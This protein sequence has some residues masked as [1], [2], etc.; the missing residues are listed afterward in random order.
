MTRTLLILLGMIVGLGSA[1][2]QSDIDTK[3]AVNDVQDPNLVVL[4]IANE[5]YKEQGFEVEDV[6]FAVRDGA[7]FEAYCKKTL[8]VKDDNINFIYD[9]TGGK[10]RAALNKLR[11]RLNAYAGNARAI[12]Y[13]SGHGMPDEATK[14]AY[15]LPVDGLPADPESAIKTSYIYKSLGNMNSKSITVFLDACFSGASREGGSLS[16]D[17]RGVNIKVKESPVGDNTV[18][19]SAAQ[20]TETAY[21]YREMQH[22]LFTYFLLEKLQQSKGGVTLGELSDYVTQQ[23][24]LKSSG[25]GAKDQTPIIAAAESNKNWR[26]WKMAATPA[27]KYV[28]TTVPIPSGGD[29]APAANKPSRPAATATASASTTASKT[30]VPSK[31]GVY[32]LLPGIYYEMVRVD[33]GTFLM[34]SK[35]TNSHSSFYMSQPIHEVALG[36]Y[37]I[38][39]TE[40][41]QELWQAVMG[42]NPSENKNPKNPVENVS[43]EDCQE[44]ISKLNEKCGTH[45]RLPTEAEWEYA[46]D[47]RIS[48]NND[49][50]SGKSHLRN[51]AHRGSSTAPCGTYEANAIG[52]Q[53]MTGNVAEWCEDYLGLYSPARQVDPRGPSKGYQRVVKGGSFKDD[54]EMMRNSFR[55]HMRAYDKAPT[56]GLRLVHD[57]K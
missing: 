27:T 20:G 47:A 4:I 51:I 1:K 29:S 46:A 30:L 40:V 57:A 45:F 33:K 7:V 31:A 12:V 32:E 55:G 17:A 21:P 41:S 25:K 42:S 48:G 36:A 43:W 5:H 19:F 49:S 23:V 53:D 50:F 16:K 10:I 35:I 24:K 18:V 14:D 39:K 52:L 34:G 2:A 22:G 3:I 15:L 28:N 13:Y 11:S 6:P 8:G 26:N 56:V 44:F 37:T 54:P 9:A 38:G